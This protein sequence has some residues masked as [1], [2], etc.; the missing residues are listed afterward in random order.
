MIQKN[1]QN[2]MNLISRTGH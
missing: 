2:A 1:P